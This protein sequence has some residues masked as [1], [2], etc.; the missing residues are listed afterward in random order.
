MERGQQTIRDVQ[1]DLL[2]GSEYYFRCEADDRQFIDQLHHEFLNRHAQPA[3]MEYWLS[4]L[5]AHGG[6]RRDVARD[7]LVAINAPQW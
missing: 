4:Q 2:S 6:L 1:L 7:F 3:E 5:D